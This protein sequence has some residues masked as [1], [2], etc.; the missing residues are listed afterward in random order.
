M[1]NWAAVYAATE[2]RGP[3]CDRCDHWTFRP[4]YTKLPKFI[5]RLCPD[6]L[7]LDS[8]LMTIKSLSISQVFRSD[9]HR[10]PVNEPIILAEAMADHVYNGD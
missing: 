10:Y 2:A 6:C 7:P 5:A 8:V 9:L 3:R 4:E 1:P